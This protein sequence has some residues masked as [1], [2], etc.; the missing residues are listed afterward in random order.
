MNNKI[1]ELSVL[2]DGYHSKYLVMQNLEVRFNEATKK[3]FYYN[4]SYRK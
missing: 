4:R 2:F 3:W 1:K